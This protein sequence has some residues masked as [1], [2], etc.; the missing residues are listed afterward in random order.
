MTDTA[1]VLDGVLLPKY[2]R[3]KRID[4]PN[5]TR[6]KT[7]GGSHYTNFINRNRSWEISWQNMKYADY[8][9]VRNIYEQMFLKRTY[10]PFQFNAEG[11]YCPVEIEISEADLALNMAIIPDFKITLTEQFGVS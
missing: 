3:L 5:K 7:L 8:V 9:T 11:I 1:M 2:G 4:T 6:V 10:C